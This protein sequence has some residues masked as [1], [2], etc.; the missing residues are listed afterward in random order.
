MWAEARKQE[1]KV[2]GIMV[3]HKKRAERRR[4]YYE[5][6]KQDPAQFLQV[7]GRSCKLHIDSNP[8]GKE[9][10]NTIMPWQGN[11]E[12]LIDRFDVRAHL[13]YIPEVSKSETFPD[14]AKDMRPTNY[15]R[16][17]ILVQNNF[18]KVKE[19]KFLKT[20]AMEE[21][22]GSKT[23]QAQKASDDKKKAALQ[24]KAAIGFTYD[25]STGPAA[26]VQSQD[27]QDIQSDSDDEFDFD[28]VIHLSALSRDQQHDLNGIGRSFFLGREDF[29]KYLKEEA[30]EQEMAKTVKQEEDEKSA[31]SGRK[32]RKERRILKEKRLAGRI[33]SPPSYATFHERN[34]KR[35]YHSSSEEDSSRSPSPEAAKKNGKVEYITTFGDDFDSAKKKRGRRGVSS[36]SRGSKR[37]ARSSS[38]SSSSDNER[39]GDD[40]S[41]YRSKYR[42]KRR[43]SSSSS[44]GVGNETIQPPPPPPVKRYYGRRCEESED[45][46]VSSDDVSSELKTESSSQMYSRANANV[47]IFHLIQIQIRV[48]L[49]LSTDMTLE[50]NKKPYSKRLLEIWNYIPVLTL[51]LFIG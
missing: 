46:D 38:S 4:E 11:A 43:S 44:S 49:L 7:N 29:V 50:T 19:E 10:S 30:E 33:P 2:R 35:R 20:I 3:D 36:S 28:T 23:Y 22:Y 32:S 5:K 13:D 21:K 1:K 24:N 17:R 12:I 42:R 15:E 39:R 14:E 51:L 18:L 16:Y 34:P 26:N 48:S 45:E 9:P 6:I 25:D 27:I 37:K 47:S 8:C 41:K 40:G 31:F